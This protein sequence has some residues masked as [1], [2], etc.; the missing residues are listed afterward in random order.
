MKRLARATV[1]FAIASSALLAAA[2]ASGPQPDTSTN[3]G[4][5]PA[6]RAAEV[7][8]GRYAGVSERSEQVPMRLSIILERGGVEGISLRLTQGRRED[9]LRH[10]R[11]LLGPTN[12]VNRLEGRFSPLAED[13]RAL[14]VCPLEVVLRDQGV[15]ART[16]AETCRFGQPPTE[17]A[18]VKE[19]AHDGQRLVIA[20]QIVDPVSG[21]P[22]DESQ[23]MVLERVAAFQGWVGV[24][25]GASEHWRVAEG[26]RLESDGRALAPV[27]AAG[28]PLDVEID[29]APYRPRPEGV[30]VLRLRV[31]D[32]DSGALLGQAW[33]DPD[34]RMIGLALAE[35]Q[36]GLIREN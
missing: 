29:L 26:M 35:V 30:T 25:D 11:L 33:G 3:A 32:A 17:A 4:L 13:G 24:R 34:A 9:E 2:C 7:L 16:A 20:D 14:G 1:R 19:I 5:A 27:D 8:V 21:Q 15:V 22:R 12:F 31:F 28:L 10:F 18:L 23:V 6:E 36:I